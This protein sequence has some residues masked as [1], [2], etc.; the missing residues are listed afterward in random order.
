[1]KYDA[2]KHRWQ[3]NEK[4]VLSFQNN[5]NNVPSRSLCR[6]RNTLHTTNTI[7]GTGRDSGSHRRPALITNMNKKPHASKNAEVIVGSMV[8]DPIEMRWKKS[9]KQEDDEE[10]EDDN[11]LA[12]IEDLG[13]LNTST[14][15]RRD[16][17]LHG[18]NNNNN[19][20]Y[21]ER[22]EQQNDTMREFKFSAAMK[23]LI[24]QQEQEHIKKMENWELMKKDESVFIPNNTPVRAFT[25]L[26]YHPHH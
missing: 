10:E 17:V 24:Q 25:Y 11:V 8:F 14:L 19:S 9:R 26:L 1:M 3:G 18:V 23:H 5:N 13:E 22:Q 16:E 21:R 15:Y 4:N 6:Q 7:T 2:E 20:Q 12:N